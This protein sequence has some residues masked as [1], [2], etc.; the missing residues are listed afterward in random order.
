MF[1]AFFEFFLDR[2][3]LFFSLGIL[4]KA[5]RALLV[6]VLQIRVIHILLALFL[7]KDLHLSVLLLA[8]GK[9][10]LE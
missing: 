3:R 9:Q 4:N 10:S 7:A 5:L 1:L 6:P 8:N 2:L